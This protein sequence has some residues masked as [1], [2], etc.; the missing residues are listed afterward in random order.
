MNKFKPGFDLP[1]LTDEVA[2]KLRNILYTFI[3]LFEAHY[4]HKIERYQRHLLANTDIL[5]PNQ[6]QAPFQS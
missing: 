1:E 4:C 2:A 5:N 6:D 3:D